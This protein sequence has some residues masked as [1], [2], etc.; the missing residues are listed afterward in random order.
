MPSTH[1][2]TCENRVKGA[3]LAIAL[4]TTLLQPPTAACAQ[5]AKLDVLRIGASGTLTG[6][7]D[8]AQE[9]AGVEILH[10]FIKEQTGLTNETVGRLQWQ[11]LGDKMSRVQFHLAVFQGYEFA[12]AQERF[13][14]LKPLAVAVNIDIYP[15]ACVLVSESSPVKGFASLRGRSL[16]V[17]TTSQGLLRLFIERQSQ[18][19]GKKPEA[20]FSKI[21]PSDNVEDA[22]DDVVDGVVQA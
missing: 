20:F 1:S 4:V 6:N 19:Q 14:R 15:V 8:S 12:W 9:K 11:E 2:R 18:G 16:A 13:P 7:S 17:P 3:Y 22:L 5:S 21:V 10:S